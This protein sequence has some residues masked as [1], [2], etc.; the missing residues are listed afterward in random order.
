M[1]NITLS[2]VGVLAAGFAT[3]AEQSRP[4]ILFILSDDHSRQA[5]SCY[6][7]GRLNQTPNLDRIAHE[8]MRLDNVFCVS[9][10]SAPSRATILTGKHSHITGLTQLWDYMKRAPTVFDNSQDTIATYMQQA[11]YQTAVVGKWHLN[12]TPRNFDYYNVLIGPWGQGEYF[13]PDFNENG[14]ERTYTGRYVTDVITEESLRWLEESRDRE[15][16]FMLFVH[17]KAPHAICEPDQKHKGMY[18]D[19]V[20][21]EPDTINDDYAGRLAAAASD[22]RLDKWTPY[23]RK[24]PKGLSPEKLRSFV[25]QAYMRDYCSVI[26][27]IDDNVGRMLNYLEKTGELDNTVVMYSS[28][29]GMFLGDHGWYNKMFMYEEPIRMPLLIRYPKEIAAGSVSSTM[30]LNVDFAQTMLDLAGIPAPRDMQGKSFRPAFSGKTPADWRDSF[31]Y[32]HYGEWV[33]PHYGVR[34]DRYKLIYFY[35]DP[36]HPEWELFDLKNDPKELSNVHNNPEYAGVVK[37]MH[38]K[39]QAVQKECGYMKEVDDGVMMRWRKR[40]AD[41]KRWEKNK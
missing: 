38:K 10:L 36:D 13:D 15:K 32:Q 9:A 41:K 23:V 4:N 30:I 27:S 24:A 34:T 26:A 14:T 2:A 20:F 40:L 28:D 11:G 12:C 8:G 19:V 3:A 35:N 16:P 1:N 33:A 18:D 37:E 29:Q 21:P 25:Y 6:N 22:Q 7:D 17:H 31:F 39:L 5:I